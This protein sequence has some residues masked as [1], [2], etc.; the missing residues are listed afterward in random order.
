M[1]QQPNAAVGKVSVAK[2]KSKNPETSS[3]RAD[4]DNTGRQ[5]KGTDS[6]Q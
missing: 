2:A 6:A 5:Q 3:K 4:N 1:K